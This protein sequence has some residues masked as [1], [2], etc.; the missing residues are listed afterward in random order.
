MVIDNVVSIKRKLSC[1]IKNDKN[2]EYI[3]TKL[4]TTVEKCDFLY[5]QTC[6]FIKLFLLYD[7]ENNKNID[8]LYNFD[9]SAIKHCFNLIINDGLIKKRKTKDKQLIDEINL[10]ESIDNFKEHLT[11]F[12]NNYKLDITNVPF[13]CPDNIGSISHIIDDLVIDIHKNIINNITLNYFKYVREYI[14][15]EIKNTFFTNINENLNT[16]N[17]P[18]IQS[19][20]NVKLITSIYNDIINNTLHSD[21]EYHQWINQHKDKIIPFFSET[22]TNKSIKTFEEGNQL[23]EFKFNKFVKSYVNNNKILKLLIKTNKSTKKIITKNIIDDLF[24]SDKTKF[25]TDIFF[26]NWINEN[27]NLI[28]NE[29]NKNNYIV[30]EDK[31]ELSPFLFLKNMLF[32]N[33][34]LE[35][36]KSKKH[37]QIIPLRTNMT[38][39]FVPICS[40]SFV[41]IIDSKYLDNTKNYY[42]NNSKS[43]IELY[44]IFFNFDFKY[45]K[46]LVKKGYEFSGLISTNGYEI[47]FNYQTKAYIEK[48]EIK[49]KRMLNNRKCNTNVIT[50]NTD[51]LETNNN[52]VN[53]NAVDNIVVDNNTVNEITITLM[54]NNI[55]QCEKI[56]NEILEKSN[57]KIESNEY[58]LKSLDELKTLMIE[59][60]NKKCDELIEQYLNGNK[61][62]TDD[63]KLKIF[64]EH[65]DNYKSSNEAYIENYYMRTQISIINNHNNTI[66][67]DYENYLDNIKLVD[68]KINDLKQKIKIVSKELLNFKKSVGHKK[69]IIVKKVIYDKPTIIKNTRLINKIRE[70]VKLLEFETENK[71][72]TKLHIKQIKITICASIL[73]IKNVVPLTEYLLKINENKKELIALFNENDKTYCINTCNNI[74]KIVYESFKNNTTKNIIKKRTM[75]NDYTETEKQNHKL[76]VNKITLL[77][78]ELNLQILNKKKI[79]NNFKNLFKEN[80]KYISIDTMSNKHFEVLN[81]LNWV[82]I[83]P[84]MNSL[85]TIS[86]KPDKDGNQKKYNY[87]KQKHLKRTNRKKTLK[88]INK[89]REEKIIPLENT[90]TKEEIR[91]KTSNNYNTFNKYHN[92]KCKIYKDVK[93]LYNDDRLNKI[94]WCS[95]INE[96]RSENMMVNDIKNKF[97]KDVVLILGDWSM[98]KGCIKGHS[99]TPNVKYTKILERE[100]MTLK[101][102][103]FRTS[104]I[105][106]KTE[107]KCI[108]LRKTYDKSNY[109][110][111]SV[112]NIENIVDE[113]KRI[114]KKK[115]CKIHKILVC[116]SNV[117]LNEKTSNT[118]NYPKNMI[119]VN[120]DNNSVN[121]MIKIVNSYI[122]SDYKPKPYIRGTKICINTFKVF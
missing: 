98:N 59:Y 75:F 97:G 41:D 82:V 63:K 27:I 31:L 23:F 10:T 86:S 62:N 58:L 20:F 34:V 12:Y 9:K 18:L 1:C 80:N 99:P 113:K 32:M 25:K 106:S 66:L 7:Y 44:N 6:N 70:K 112:F 95:Y 81:K 40:N 53:N 4:C 2:G 116:N 26:H 89:I 101:I 21:N 16:D 45:D 104:I 73:K 100:F 52:I 122:K 14:K 78:N 55:K 77:N 108:N 87:T 33:K 39:K 79:D 121:N 48:K 91:M 51:I 71:D 74:I 96:K 85:F 84:G 64:L 60:L 105:H 68:K 13:E 54:E 92:N 37:Y 72:I 83:D 24:C 119:Y 36:N 11:N 43:I 17:D 107:K 120:R 118:G 115:I 102:D 65:I 61:E 28:I 103:E 49:Q 15:I 35:L 57:H 69:D 30:I 47:V 42:H 90:L 114:N 22:D 111:K 38:P 76:I 67:I 29:F 93:T 3:K 5:F 8:Q 50:N 109:N 19:K 117:K 94:T 88:K 56:C 46:N 110:I